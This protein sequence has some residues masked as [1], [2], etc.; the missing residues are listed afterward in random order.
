VHWPDSACSI[1]TDVKPQFLQIADDYTWLNPHL[2][3]PERG[4]QSV[5]GDTTIVPQ[6]GIDS[7][8]ILVA[9]LIVSPGRCPR[10]PG[11]LVATGICGIER[12]SRMCRDGHA[13]ADIL[14]G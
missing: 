13:V 14:H 10:V 9:P 7:V 6:C 12:G 4:P 1:L 5:A 2:A 8:G 11:S 3:L